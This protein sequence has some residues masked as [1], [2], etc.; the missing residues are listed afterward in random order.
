MLC[1][2]MHIHAMLCC[3]MICHAM[4]CY[5][6]HG[7]VMLCYAVLLACLL[8]CLLLLEHSVTD[9]PGGASVIERLLCI[10]YAM[11]CYAMELCYAMLRYAMLYYAR[12]HSLRSGIPWHQVRSLRRP[13]CC[14]NLKNSSAI[15]F[16]AG[17]LRVTSND[18]VWWLSS[19]FFKRRF[20]LACSVAAL[21]E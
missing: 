12:V 8:A 10:C 20:C 6:M 9:I 1:Y 2:I 3:S 7:Y 18:S 13:S 14:M 15:V 11:L 16:A 5:A 4:L 17:L 21:V 19:C